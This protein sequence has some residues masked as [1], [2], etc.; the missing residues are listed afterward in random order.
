[1]VRGIGRGVGVFPLPQNKLCGLGASRRSS[2]GDG[3]WC[4]CLINL[5]RKCWR[6]LLMMHVGYHNT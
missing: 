6:S 3:G 4:W 1:M 2:C 5:L